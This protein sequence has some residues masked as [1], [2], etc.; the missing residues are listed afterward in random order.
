VTPPASGRRPVRA[1]LADFGGTLF[2]HHSL[3]RTLVAEAAALGVTLPDIEATELAAEIDGLAEAADGRDLDAGRWEE[4]FGAFYRTADRVR[5]GLGPRLYEAMHAAHQWLPYADT[6]ALLGTLAAQGVPVVVVSNTGWDVRAPFVHHGLADLV[7]GWVLS[8]EVGVA[9]P[10]PRIFALACDLVGVAPGD[11][12]M[13]GDN[14]SAD[15]GAALC[16]IPTLVL[17]PSPPEAARGLDAVLDLVSARSCRR[18]ARSGRGWPLPG[19]RE[20]R[21]E[22]GVAT[23]GE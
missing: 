5:P 19:A 3:A 1:V 21:T 23:A 15:G 11:T 4:R 6:P 22:P 8:C 13:V 17:P 10:D 18:T 12:L 16:G 20:V 2:A 14:P 9:K 7:S